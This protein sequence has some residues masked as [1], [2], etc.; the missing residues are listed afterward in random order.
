MVPFQKS[1]MEQSCQLFYCEDF[2]KYL[3]TN[4]NTIG[5]INKIIEVCDGKACARPGKPEDYIMMTT[6]LRYPD[7]KENMSHNHPTVL[8][9]KQWIGQVFVDDHLYHHFLKICASFLKGRNAE[10]KFHVWTGSGNNSKSMIIKLLQTT[11]GSYCIDFPMALLTGKAQSSS[12]P[13][14]ELAQSKGAHIA[15][16]AEPD[17]EEKMKGG[18]IK[19]YTGGDR[20]FARMCNQNGG[21]I[22][23]MFK[24][25][26]M[27]NDIPAIPS[28]GQ[29]VRN[30]LSALPFLSKW[31]DNPPETEEEQRRQRRFRL[32]PFFEEQIP[33]LA[34]AFMWLLVEYFPIYI[35]EGIIDPPIVR[36]TTEQYWRDN[37]PYQNYIEEVV[38]QAT[39]RDT[40]GKESI[41]MGTSL[42]FTDL[43]ADFKRW[44]RENF[45]GSAIPNTTQAKPQF[46][47]RLGEQRQKRWYGY[48][49]S[50][51][52]S[53]PLLQ[54]VQ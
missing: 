45:P 3:D 30:R 50:N 12:G 43:F 16:L 11:F 8:K 47:R 5:L 27:C 23:A 49:L 42:T 53:G 15:V 48:R 2:V 31:V 54:V 13:N 22:E 40:T 26:L 20:F 18:T 21:S 39:I 6:F 52:L 33:S 34:P 32:D 36:E 25:I 44:F 38:V 41:D 7:A 24:T 28:G 9:L 29:A 17:E 51:P 35:Q 14:P 10:K 46:L 4:P 37:D 1:I 19:R